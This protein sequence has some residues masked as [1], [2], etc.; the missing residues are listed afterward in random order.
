M[1]IKITDKET[2]FLTKVLNKSLNKIDNIYRFEGYI[3]GLICSEE[4]MLPSVFMKTMFGGPDDEDA[5]AWESIEQLNEFMEIYSNVNNK[6]ATKL[7]SHIYRP[8]FAKSKEQLKDY[9]YGF[10]QSYD[11]KNIVEDGNH[12]ANLA[13]MIIASFLDPSEE[14]CKDDASYANLVKEIENKP[15]P[16]ISLAVQVL[17]HFRLSN[18]EAPQDTANN[19]FNFDDISRTYH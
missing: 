9:A 4:T 14:M 19:V 10:T 5:M 1:S 12:E 15:L 8:I 3:V 6:N 13:F 16:S 2:K 11:A 18:Y 17:N 7:Q